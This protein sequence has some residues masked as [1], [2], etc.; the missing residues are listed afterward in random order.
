VKRAPLEVAADA[1]E[2]L[3]VVAPVVTDR[4]WTHEEL[5]AR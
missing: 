5:F 3:G 4:V 1:I 2:S